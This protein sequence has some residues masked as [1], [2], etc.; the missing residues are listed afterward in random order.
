[1]LPWLILYACHCQR[2]RFVSFA[3]LEQENQE[4]ETANDE[5][6]ETEEKDADRA[7]NNI[8]DPDPVQA[9]DLK[10]H[11]KLVSAADPI[12][13][14]EVDSKPVPAPSEPDSKSL[15]DQLGFG[16]DETPITT[17]S[18]SGEEHSTENLKESPTDCSTSCVVDIQNLVRPFTRKQLVD[19]LERSGRIVE[20]GFW[21]NRNKSHA[22]VKV[23]SS[24]LFNRSQ[25]LRKSFW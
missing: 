6:V 9:D 17:K 8:V 3:E 2:K 24:T 23:N 10:P 19:L 11:P 16:E 25:P 13:T 4:E 14:P 20:N 15:E 12:P 5:S 21:I 7:N 1:V 18:S 22:I